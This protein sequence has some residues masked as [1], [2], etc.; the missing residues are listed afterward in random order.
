MRRFA[1]LL[2]ALCFAACGN[3]KNTSRQEAAAQPFFPIADYINGQLQEIKKQGLKVVRYSTKNGVTSSKLTDFSDMQEAAAEFTSPDITQP[4]LSARY[5]EASFAD[6]SVPNI[7]LTY[8][9]QDRSLEIQRVDVILEPN[10]EASDKVKTIYIEKQKGSRQF[11]LLWTADSH[12]Q[13]ISNDS[14]T[15]IVKYVWNI[16]K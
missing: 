16:G 12:F 6:Q 15:T 9:A 4:P 3:K 13:I 10:P 2:L 5:K 11:K 7:T 8:S 1:Y 14:G